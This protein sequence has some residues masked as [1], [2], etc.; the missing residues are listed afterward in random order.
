V[1]LVVAGTLSLAIG[2]IGIYLPVL[3]TTPFLLLSAA[4]YVRSSDRMYHWLLTQP[5]LGKEIHAIIEQRALPRKLKILSLVFAWTV[6]GGLAVFVV[7]STAAK[8]LLIVLALV[9]TGVLMR[10]KSA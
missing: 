9:K 5:R 3:P 7:E 1:I 4:C 6:L 2:A 10:M 8:V